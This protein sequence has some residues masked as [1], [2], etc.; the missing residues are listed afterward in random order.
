MDVSFRLADV[1]TEVPFAG[2]Q[3][4]VVP[5]TPRDVGTTSMQMLAREIGFS[6]TTFVSSADTAG[7][8]MRIFTPDAEIPFAGHPTLGTSFTLASEGMI[9]NDVVQT[10]SAGDVRVEVDL[11]GGSALMHQL[12]PVFGDVFGHRELAALAAGL[13]LDDLVEALPVQSVGTGLKSLMVP[14]KDEVTLRR[15]ER[16]ARACAD[17]AAAAKTDTLYFFTVRADGDVMARMFDPGVGIGEDP[18]TGSAA[19]PLGAYLA[20]ND[21][22]G[23]AGGVPITVAQGEM[24]NRPSFLHVHIAPDGDGWS[25]R[26]G[27]GVQI[28][29]EGTFRF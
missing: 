10:T 7:Y 9:G 27:G 21:L 6:E 12:P 19:G 13:R 3:L 11:P 17:L 5:A 24:V 25:V 16:D 22:A 20:A 28:V 29:G 1:F 26:V 23:A 14:V 15:A 2:N 18:A 8:R 4:C